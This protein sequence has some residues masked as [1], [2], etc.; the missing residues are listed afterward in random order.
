[1]KKIEIELT[2]EFKKETTKAIL[3]IVLFLFVYSLLF[4]ITIGLTVLC[5][6]GGISLI[7]LY[8]G[9][10]TIALGIGL[11]SI[12][13]LVLLFLI[14]F[15][16][17]SHKIDRS[18]LLEIKKTEEPELFKMIDEIVEKVGTDFPK[19]V[20]LSPDVNAGV[21]YDSSFW[22]MFFP[23]KK[24]LQIGVGLINTISKDEL[25]AILAHEFGH[26]SQKSMKVGSYVHNVNQVI[27]NMLYDNESYDNLVQSWANISGYFSVFVVLAIKIIEGIQWLLKQMYDQVNISY[28]SLSREMEFHADEIAANL[29]GYEP[30][31]ESLLRMDLADNS[32]NAVIGYYE[33]KI[34]EN[35]TSKNIFKEQSFALRYIGLDNELSL[36]KDIPQVT[37]A[38]ISKFNKSKLNIK[39]Q[40]QSHP[41]VEERISRLEK[42]NMNASQREFFLANDVLSNSNETQ[43]R[44]TENLF[45]NIEYKE[46]PQENSLEDY[47]KDFIKEYK[48]NSFSEI[49]NGYYNDKTIEEFDLDE[50]KLIEANVSVESFYFNDKVDLVSISVALKNDIEILNQIEE[51]L[52]DIKTFDYDGKKHKKSEAGTLIKQL[53]VE[54]EEVNKKVKENDIQIFSFFRTIEKNIGTN[55][56]QEKY[57][58]FFLFDKEFDRKFEVYTNLINDLEFISLV[59]PFDVIKTNFIKIKTQETILK[60]ILKGI[61]SDKKYESTFT[62]AI[63]ENIE[64]YISKDWVYFEK[65][66]YNDENLEIISFALNNYVFLLSRGY[67]LFK[68]ELLDY[69]VE[70]MMNEK[71]KLEKA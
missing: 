63:K 44:I 22:S 52:I 62:T 20:Y 51:K 66:K 40:W 59:T 26:F 55:K 49:Y 57:K 45:K 32:F 56:L 64:T 48:E 53:D 4:V 14:K 67:F 54:L 60:E 8:P 61:L 27:F 37:A 25:R 15:I 50:A 1:M 7:S 71:Q 31:K 43:K 65:E 34:E 38:Y 70:L 5:A 2:K 28:M 3:S 21:F 47:K 10:I 58:E 24:N 36:L 69:Q 17:K 30:L 29:T 68:K 46:T 33:N 9:F 11:A 18:H 19:K 41:T 12:G 35:I 6:Y 23:V 39:D 42:L 13:F 16:F